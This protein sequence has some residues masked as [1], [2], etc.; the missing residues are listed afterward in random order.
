MASIQTNNDFKVLLTV[1]SFLHVIY[2]N[3]CEN[4][5]ILSEKPSI[6]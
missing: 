2:H 5:E 6:F 4:E 1:I 3:S